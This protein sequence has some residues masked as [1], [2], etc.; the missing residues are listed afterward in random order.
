MTIPCPRRSS[1]AFLVF[2]IF[3]A[4]LWPAS[5]RAGH[6]S[7]EDPSQMP[8]RL[9]TAVLAKQPRLALLHLR[10]GLSYPPHRVFIRIFKKERVLEL[11]AADK[12]GP[13]RHVES[14]P[15][16]AASGGLGPKRRAGDLQVP[17]GFYNV[18]VLNP[19]SAYHLSL[20]VNYPNRSDRILGR[21]GSLGGAIMI[22]GD[23]VSIGCV[24][25][26]DSHIEEVY[27][28]AMESLRR[29]QS[30]VP[31]HIFP[32]RLDRNG[33]A[34]LREQFAARPKLITFWEE[35]EPGFGFFEKNRRVPVIRI[36]AKGHYRLGE[37]H[38]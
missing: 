22:H 2:A 5:T 6:R 31:I 7:S 35:L 28:T 17:E 36:D 3:A 12:K 24:A 13:F 23:C 37:R 10:Q 19:W 32:T 20:G 21:R 30:K 1:P 18:T 26:T 29:G 16:C 27:V 9:A 8:P 34:F 33:M 38:E 4:H 15:V 11:W 14:Y 25:I